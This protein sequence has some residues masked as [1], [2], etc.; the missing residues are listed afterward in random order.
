MIG[1][2]FGVLI[3]L[4]VGTAHRPEA[5]SNRAGERLTS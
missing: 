2:S 1:I 3:G 4:A 5:R